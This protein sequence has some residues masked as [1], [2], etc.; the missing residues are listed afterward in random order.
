M[1]IYNILVL[2]I[3]F[4]VPHVL[5]DVL[6]PYASLCG[7]PSKM[8]RFALGNALI[9]A[10]ALASVNATSLDSLSLEAHVCALAL[11]LW[12]CWNALM[13]ARRSEGHETRR[14]QRAYCRWLRIAP[15]IEA[16]SVSPY[17]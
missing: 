8:E 4:L 7:L 15:V 16:T 3:Q 9:A 5:G 14:K 17:A 1:G 12:V 11:V 6:R 10:G 13:Y 2:H